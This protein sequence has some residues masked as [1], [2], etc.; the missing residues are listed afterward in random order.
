MTADSTTNTTQKA[1]VARSRITN[2]SELLPGIDQRSTWARLFRDL[3][4][5]LIEHLGGADRLTEPER[6]TCRRAATLEV[7]L[8]HMEAGFAE[9]RAKGQAPDATTLDLYSRLSNAQ[10]RALEG[11]GFDRRL[12]DVVHL[13]D[14]IAGGSQ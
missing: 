14:Y 10:R 7:E 6:M 1:P 13:D 2:G 5:A 3:N 9:T 8:V 12:S 4:N 11:I